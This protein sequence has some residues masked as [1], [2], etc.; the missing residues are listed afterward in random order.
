MVL[1]ALRRYRHLKFQGT[2]VQV[3][4]GEIRI[5]HLGAPLHALIFMPGVREIEDTVEAL[6]G[7]FRNEVLP[8]FGAMA[9]GEQEAVVE[10]AA[11]R[12]ATRIFVSTEL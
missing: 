6:R 7:E 8:L 2:T 4:E 9:V 5:E 3:G 10:K 12:S 11:D 1:K